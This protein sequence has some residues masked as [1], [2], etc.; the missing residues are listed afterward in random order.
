M[1]YKSEAQK[2]KL[3]DLAKRGEISG[4]IVNAYDDASKGLSLPERV[5]PGRKPKADKPPKAWMNKVIK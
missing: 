5:K 3:H 1:A 4:K 2:R